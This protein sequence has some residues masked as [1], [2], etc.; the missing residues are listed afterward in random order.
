LYAEVA[1]SAKHAERFGKKW[2]SIQ[3]T[4]FSAIFAISATSAYRF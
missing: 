4:L 2:V 3:F 1:E